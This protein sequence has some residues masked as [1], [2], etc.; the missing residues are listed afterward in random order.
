MSILIRLPSSD[1]AG[2][3]TDFLVSGT[4][5]STLSN[6]SCSNCVSAA[7]RDDHLSMR[8]LEAGVDGS[9]LASVRNS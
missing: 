4:S 2:H 1:I 8:A 9:R 7:E 3:G 6:V 5:A